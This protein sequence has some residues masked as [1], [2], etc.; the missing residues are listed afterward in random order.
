MKEGRE[1][2]GN[3]GRKGLGFWDWVLIGGFLA[4]AGILLYPTISDQW[5]RYRNSRLI[6]EY[7]RAVETLS[8]ESYEEI[9]EEAR[10]YNREH[11]V[12]SPA[13]AFGE[14]Y[15]LSHPYDKILDP[16]GDGVMG[17]IEIPK[18]HV[19]LGIYHG[20]GTDVLEEGCGHVEGT[21]L[22]IG[23][24]GSHA[25]LAAHRGLPSA[26]L[27]TDLDQL[28]EGDRFYLRILDEVLCYEVDQI[29][30]VLPRETGELSIEE[31][32][33]YVTLVTC[34]PYGV[35]S[36]RLLVRGKRREYREEEAEELQRAREEEESRAV[37]AA[38]AG[39]GAVFLLLGGMVFVW[40]KRE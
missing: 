1:K 28:E 35:N 34:T 30:V 38:A 18:I 39:I 10:A 37:Q 21:S 26:R 19:S 4:G 2:S 24:E 33:D 31:G 6:A 40:R 36:H 29:K 32:E 27:F 12:N 15:E 14:A 3:L 23:G 16:F 22:P 9:W 8:Q 20:I 11:R 13:E 7:G 5:N 25:A 17:S